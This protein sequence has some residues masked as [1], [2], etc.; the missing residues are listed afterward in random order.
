M[1]GSNSKS[2]EWR[3]GLDNDIFA[4]R[5]G[6]KVAVIGSGISGLSAAWLL[7]KHCDVTLYEADD[8]LG[9]HANTVDIRFGLNTI[10]VD[11]GFIVY[12]D[13]NYPNLVALFEHLGVPTDSSNMS[14]A[15]SLDDGR[16][17]YSGCGLSGLLG[18]RSNAIRP[19]FWR[20]VSDILR[21]YK[22]A[23]GLLE[24]TDLDTATIGDYLDAN[25][26]SRAFVEDHLMPM[27]AAIWS[28][29]ADDMRGYPLHAFIRFFV[30]H[31][32]V[33]LK[34]RPQ[35]RTVTGGSRE[36]VSRLLADF[37]GTVRRNTP[38]ASIARFGGR[39][40]VTDTHGNSD[41]YSDIVVATHADQALAL[42]SDADERE[43]ALLG[44]FDYTPNTAV[45]HSDIRL[46]PKRK[47]VWASWNY[48]AVRQQSG[49]SPLCVTYWMN[50][51]Q[52]LDPSVPLFVTL[53]PSRDIDPAKVH[54]TVHYS[55]PLFDQKAMAAQKQLWQLQG[56]RNT[57]FCGA[58]FGAGFHEDGLQSG[59]AAAESL[60]GIRRPWSV[61]DES[62][63]IHLGP[64]SSNLMAAE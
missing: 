17:E 30:N 21:F 34:D 20:M 13:R 45:L 40:T 6:R 32:L 28:S 11:T 31:G 9:G 62:A 63:R 1:T 15:A 19:R 25:H 38:I 8:R 60:A 56:K 44:A 39:V 33:V 7:S 46:M 35:W 26:Y 41:L 43:R 55:H 57:W 14:F 23:P 53:N 18:Q 5:G 3:A 48:I 4:P 10:A 37:K 29:S 12:N 16:F 58:H 51:L 61:K 27:G 54:S 22:Q 64:R 50:Q 2:T 59:L 52:N 36:Y 47:Q 24:R 49:D 42:L